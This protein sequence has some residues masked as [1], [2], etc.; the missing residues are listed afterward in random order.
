[1]GKFDSKYKSKQK[2]KVCSKFRLTQYLVTNEERSHQ[3]LCQKFD[4]PTY[5][6]HP[7]QRNVIPNVERN[8]Y[9]LRHN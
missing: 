7:E 5:K 8:P 1:M 9:R 2:T 6:H 4:R 3:S